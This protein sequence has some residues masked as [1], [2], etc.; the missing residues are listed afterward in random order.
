MLIPYNTDAPIYYFPYATIGLIVANVLIYFATAT[1]AANDAPPPIDPGL[2]EMLLEQTDEDGQPLATQEELEAVW[3]AEQQEQSGSLLFLNYSP[4][5]TWLTLEFDQINPLQWFTHNFMHADVMHLLG[6]M[7]FL[8]GF[9]IV[10]EGKLGWL[11]FLLVYGLVCLMQ[12][13]FIQI[14]MFF[15]SDGVG[16]ALGA[17]GA[18]YGMMAIAV[19]WAPKNEMSCL[20]FWRFIPRVIEI[21]IITFGGFYLG[22]QLVF[23]ALRGFS[24]SSEALHLSGL[25][26]GLVPGIVMLKRNLVDCEGWDAFTVY[27]ATPEQQDKKRDE[28]RTRNQR[29]ELKEAKEEHEQGL[30]RKLE[31]LSNAIKADQARPAI[32]IYTKFK[33]EFQ[34]GKK[35]PN[36]VLQKLISLLHANKEWEDSI[37]LMVELLQR[38]PNEKVSGARLKLSQIL[39]QITDQPKQAIAVLRKLPKELPPKQSQLRSKLAR[40]AKSKLADSY[41]IEVHDW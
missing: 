13:A 21:P 3:A 14:I 31:A 2:M 35:L 41:E 17:S 22:L 10:V 37:P 32:A 28:F 26:M 7:I 16:L 25:L 34:Q 5:V 20:L 27:A 40:L 24:M 30:K 1:I 6:N 23:F 19:L 38:H 12:G 4:R 8:W 39:I 9:G 15:A 33:S 36:N 11:R 29:A 18:I